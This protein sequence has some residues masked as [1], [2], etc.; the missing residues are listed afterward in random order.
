MARKD[1]RWITAK[2]ATDILSANAQ[3]PIPASYIR[4]LVRDGKVEVKPIDGRTNLYKAS[5]V[6]SYIV[7][8]R[9]QVKPKQAQE[10]TA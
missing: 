7:K 6:E 8:R 2:E 9:G 10:A 5:D 4:S 3:R 1:D